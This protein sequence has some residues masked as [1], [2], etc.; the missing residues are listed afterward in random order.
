MPLV[1]T[2]SGALTTYVTLTDL[3][4]ER[5]PEEAGYYLAYGFNDDI[6]TDCFYKDEKWWQGIVQSI[7]G[8]T[9]WQPLPAPPESPEDR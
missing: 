8:V 7:D 3:V 1:C 4:E 2:T 5:L 6:V 9:H